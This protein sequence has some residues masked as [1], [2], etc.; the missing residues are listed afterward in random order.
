MYWNQEMLTFLSVLVTILGGR[1]VSSWSPATG[2]LNWEVY[3]P[4]LEEKRFVQAGFL[5]SSMLT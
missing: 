1:R 5:I 3:L 4:G 2:N